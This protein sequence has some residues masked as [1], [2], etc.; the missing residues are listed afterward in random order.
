MKNKYVYTT[1]LST[2]AVSCLFAAEKEKKETVTP[3]IVIIYCDDLGYGD[4]GITGHPDIKTPNL[5][6][7][8]TNGIRFTNYYSASP[9]S[10]A[11]RYALLTGRYPPRAGFRWVL[12]PDS[13][14]GIHPQEVTLAEALKEK[15]YATA[16][17]G[18]WHLGSTKKEYLPLQNGFDEWV[19]FPYSN[20]MLPPKYQDIALMCG[21]DTLE[22]NPD[23][24][25]LTEMFTEKATSF[26]RENKEKP[27]FLYVPYSMPHTPLYPGKAFLGKSKRG[28]Y[29]DAVEEIDWGVGQILETLREAGVEK[30]TI[31]W[32]ASDNGPWV[33]QNEKGGSAGLFRDGKG[34]TWEGGMRV[35][36]FVSWPGRLAPQINEAIV[37]SM[38][39]FVTSVYMGGGTVPDDRAIDGENIASYL[40]YT[41]MPTKEEDTPFFYFGINHQLMAVRKGEWKLH[42]K[43]YSQ[44]NIDY[45]NGKLPLLFNIYTDPSEK[46]D[47]AD[48]HPE[49]VR[50][51]TLLLEEKKKE[52]ETTGSWK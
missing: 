17:F 19:G 26:I 30:N 1:L 7:M 24:S 14:Q 32:F 22:L 2:T 33:I 8:A 38:D 48:K 51:L 40:G 4:I 41:Q 16:M 47:L 37:T 9:A 11:S 27:F 18:K 49:I 42:V 28:L 46:Y 10:T 13:E 31:V 12:N 45:Y 6:R 50:E 52:V 3:N 43:T 20:D 36:C 15:G 39:I 21:N 25:F 34:S 29:G 23:Q 5:D 35:P 44:L